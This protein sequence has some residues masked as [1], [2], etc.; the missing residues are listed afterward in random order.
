MNIGPPSA[1][2]YAASGEGGG[3]VY[4]SPDGGLTWTTQIIN[5]FCT[6]QCFYDVAVAVDPINANNVYLGGSPALIFGRSVD[7]GLTFTTN[8]TTAN[9]AA[10]R[11]TRDRGRTLGSRDHLCRH[12]WRDMEIDEQR[13]ELGTR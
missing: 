4:R 8:A 13:V 6:P 7:G 2:V 11:Y 5:G 1:V 9:R 10:R 3:S 12:R